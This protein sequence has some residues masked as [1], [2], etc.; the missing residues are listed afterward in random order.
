MLTITC[1]GENCNPVRAAGRGFPAALARGGRQPGGTRPAIVRSTG[2]PDG[3]RAPERGRDRIDGA[4]A[5][6]EPPAR[7]A[8]LT[9]SM[10]IEG[11]IPAAVSASAARSRDFNVRCAF[12][13]RY[14]E[15]RRRRP[16]RPKAKLRAQE[17]DDAAA[18]HGAQDEYPELRACS[19]GF[20]CP[21]P[22]EMLDLDTLSKKGS[23]GLRIRS[24]ATPRG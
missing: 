17:G 24:E 21:R 22:D 14:P 10:A 5:R 9:A 7:R 20:H 6:T 13:Q 4:A 23:R 15:G 16:F 18:I 2:E 3:D 19:R 12:R 8:S 11:A 1:G